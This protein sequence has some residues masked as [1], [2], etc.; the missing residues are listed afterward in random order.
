[1]ASLLDAGRKVCAIGAW[2]LVIR[3]ANK[4][5]ASGAGRALSFAQHSPRVL[6]PHFIGDAGP[7]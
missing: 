3:P 7:R 1:V 4:R 5:R 2:P 6:D